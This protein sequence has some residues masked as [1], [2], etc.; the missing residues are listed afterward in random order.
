MSLAL[1]GLGWGVEAP[2]RRGD[3]L[4]DA[5]RDVDLLLIATPD[6]A[7]AEVAAAI[8]PVETTVV[9]HLAG[10]RGLDVLANHQ[11]RAALHP[12][13]SIP[14]PE[15]GAQRLSGGAWFALAGDPLVREIVDALGGHALEVADEDPATY[16]A[17][18][19]IASNH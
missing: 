18:A 12:L 9:A 4:A 7:I 3:A 16:H 19:C 17:A 15:T 11:R 1:E 13:V 2:R 14:D 5:A 8:E 6:S 10:S